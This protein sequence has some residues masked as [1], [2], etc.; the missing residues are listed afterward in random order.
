M[1]SVCTFDRQKP[2]STGKVKDGRI[3]LISTYPLLGAILSKLA[4]QMLMEGASQSCGSTVLEWCLPGAR[5]QISVCPAAGALLPT[6]D[7]GA[8]H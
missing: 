4:G 6:P 2:K 8:A 1:T 3:N 5:Q 7:S